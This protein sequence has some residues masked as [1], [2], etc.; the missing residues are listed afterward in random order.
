[1]CEECLGTYTE[2]PW[3]ENLMGYGI[4]VSFSRYG[5]YG[6]C[7]HIIVEGLV[8]FKCTHKIVKGLVSNGGPCKDYT[9]EK[10][11][12]RNLVELTQID[13]V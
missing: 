11:L 13:G 10:N 8:F 4:R 1:M 3:R 2:K 9:W 7:M 12:S 6:K 5:N